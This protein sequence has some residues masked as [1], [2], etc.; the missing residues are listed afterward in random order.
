MDPNPVTRSL[1]EL[2]YM[3]F[4]MGVMDLQARF[5]FSVTSWWR[6]AKHNAGLAD[7]VKDSQHL[8][9]TAADVVFD[10]GAEPDPGLFKAAARELGLE[11]ERESDHTHLELFTTMY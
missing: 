3:T 6:T 4:V 7:S 1:R 9:G 2:R 8:V 5:P 11:V 10:P